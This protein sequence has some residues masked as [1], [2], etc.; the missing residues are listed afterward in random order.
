MSPFIKPPKKRDKRM[1]A[2]RSGSFISLT[3][4][5]QP[6]GKKHILDNGISFKGEVTSS[7]RPKSKIVC[8]LGPVSRT[9][10]ILEKMLKAGMSIAR[11]NFSHGSHEY[12]QETLDN[13]RQ[14]SKNTGIMCARRRRRE[15]GERRAACLLLL[16]LARA[17]PSRN[18]AMSC[19]KGLGRLDH[20]E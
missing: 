17:G 13:L 1:T 20:Y 6:H 14:A 19:T 8:T 15:G 5:D 12:H 16:L 4:D 10:P 7:Y 11:F 9:V 18:D 2:K 3:T